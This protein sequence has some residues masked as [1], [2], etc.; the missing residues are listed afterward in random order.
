MLV[1]IPP[2]ATSR[3]IGRKRDT[4]RR[5][6]VQ[7]RVRIVV[8]DNTAIIRGEKRREEADEIR[9]EIESAK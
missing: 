7:F 2:E 5:L 1:T 3:I 8:D 4:I 6:E 9:E